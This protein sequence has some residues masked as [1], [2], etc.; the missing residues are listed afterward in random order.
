MA[1]NRFRDENMR[2]NCEA[3]GSWTEVKELERKLGWVPRPQWCPEVDLT[4][5]KPESRE[6]VLAS[7]GFEAE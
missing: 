2:I 7:L 4:A 1:G 3:Y 5:L 6:A